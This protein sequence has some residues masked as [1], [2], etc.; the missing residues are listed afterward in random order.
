MPGSVW[1]K[2][3]QFFRFSEGRKEYFCDLKIGIF[4]V[5]SYIVDRTIL[6]T[7]EYFP[8]SITVILDV[9]PIS[10]I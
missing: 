5:S 8:D 3:N 10:D 6:G 9:E 7:S 4:I 2:R 1:N